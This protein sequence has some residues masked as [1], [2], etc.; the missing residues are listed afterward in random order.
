MILTLLG[1]I[2]P[3]EKKC[4]IQYAIS[5]VGQ[6][7]VIERI[8]IE[9]VLQKCYFFFFIQIFFLITKYE[10]QKCPKAFPKTP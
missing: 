1:H 5:H 7:Q 3:D 2:P 9:R 4:F 8:V 10:M 6:I